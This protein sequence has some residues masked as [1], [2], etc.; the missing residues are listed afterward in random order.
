MTYITSRDPGGDYTSALSE[1]HRLLLDYQSA[2]SFLCQAAR[3]TARTVG[4]SLSCSILLQ[5]G[6][7]ALA[8]A[9]SDPLATVSEQVQESTGQGP[10]L[11]CLRW[12]HLVRVDNLCEDARWPL[13]TLRATEVGIRSCL[14]LPLRA[15]GTSG[16]LSLYA[17]ATHAFGAPQISRASTFA[18]YLISALAIGARQEGLLSTIDQ[19]RTALASRAVIDQAIGVIMSR[20]HCTSTQAMAMLRTQ[21][22]HRN[23]KLR[24]LAR[25]I[26]TRA[27]G[28]PPRLPPFETG[29]HPPG[30]PTVQQHSAAT[31]R[32]GA[33]HS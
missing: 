5:P 9:T 8:I 14:C 15:P 20:D 18:D 28:G 11:R 16:A 10:S 7:H 30:R 12:Q 4:S 31:A 1:L 19:M 33:D 27:S 25:E 22:Q 13:F 17:P 32:D 26:V 3:L 6:G 21:S 2:E 23:L 29:S 24:N